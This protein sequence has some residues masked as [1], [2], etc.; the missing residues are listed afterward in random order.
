MRCYGACTQVV[1]IK[2]RCAARAGDGLPAVERELD[3]LGMLNKALP[4]DIRVRG[5]CPLPDDFTARCDALLDPLPPHLLVTLHTP[6]VRGGFR[7]VWRGAARVGQWKS[8][9]HYRGSHA[10]SRPQ[11]HTPVD[12]SVCQAAGFQRVK[13]TISGQEW[14]EVS[15]V[16]RGRGLW[17]TW[18]EFIA[19]AVWC[20]RLRCASPRLSL[21]SRCSRTARR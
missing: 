13:R 1:S 2:L 18:V 3:Y 9:A 7:P 4:A 5:W 12:R 15:A 21:R 11:Q 20:L 10:H 16:K 19:T 8:D 17:V 6:G 14:W